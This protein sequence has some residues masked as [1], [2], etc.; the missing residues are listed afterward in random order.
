LQRTPRLGLERGS[1]DR[2]QDRAAGGANLTDRRR[3]DGSQP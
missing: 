1:R 2:Q 3:D